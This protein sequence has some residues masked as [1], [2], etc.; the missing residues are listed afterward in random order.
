[1]TL[2]AI[3]VT[4]ELTQI[5][6]G[7]CGGTYAIAERYRQQKYDKGEYWN[8]PYCKCSWGYGE[9]ELARA[10]KELEAEKER[11][12]RTL[13]RE[14]EAIAEK[15]KL[16]RKLKR[17]QRG[18]CPQCNRTFTNLARHMECKHKEQP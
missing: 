6:C 1:M 13:A 15:A 8:C 9:G 3:H 11:H 12:R 14:N 4:L 17:V 10:Q 2:P 16:D 18:V 5:T 7:Q